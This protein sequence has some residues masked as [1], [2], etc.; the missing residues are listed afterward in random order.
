[1][2]LRDGIVIKDA[3]KK[4]PLLAIFRSPVGRRDSEVRLGENMEQG[5]AKPLSILKVVCQSPARF[6]LHR[7]NGAPTFAEGYKKV[8]G[9][10]CDADGTFGNA[11]LGV[12]IHF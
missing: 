10:L 9:Y 8:M 4:H 5:Q 11:R 2:V 3:S 1:M 12:I 6:L 7:A